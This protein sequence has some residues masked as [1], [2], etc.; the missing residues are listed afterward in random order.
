[1]FFDKSIRVSEENRY[2]GSLTFAIFLTYL[3]VGLPL[4]VIP[5]FVYNGL[6][7]SNTLVGVAVGCQFFATVL[8]RA[9]AG[10]QADSVGAKRTTLKGMLICSMAGLAYLLSALLP[11]PDM[12]RYGI[13]IVGRLFLGLGESLL[14]S[15]NFAWALGLIG[16]T[17]SGKIMSWNGMAIYGS[18]AAGAPL[19]LLLNHHFGFV[20][21]GVSTLV[22]PLLAFLLDWR[23]RPI[24][25]TGGSKVSLLSVAKLV[26]QPG[27]ALALQG[28]G[29]AVIGTFMSLLFASYGWAHA[30]L[31]LS[32]FGVAFVGVR[33]LFGHLPDKIGGIK[34]AMVS[35]L[36]ESVGLIYL[37]G[38]RAVDGTGRGDGGRLR[39][40]THVPRA[41]GGSRQA[42]AHSGAWHGSWG[43]CRV[44]GRGLYGDR[45]G[46]GISGDSSGVSFGFCDRGV[47]RHFRDCRGAAFRPFRVACADRMMATCSGHS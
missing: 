2:L 33:V 8:S 27:L 44:S 19:G 21:L 9:Y 41:R 18:L 24:E 29:F 38:D 31:T 17:K 15:G 36:V 6:N 10:R 7:L 25:T 28:A 3:T 14:I 1:M 11:V 40:F 13:L 47:L 46:N 43:I 12:M 20:A 22:L 4:P 16:T 5:L 23:I 37:G 34:V 42:G 32:C 39:L 35:L 26:W 30:G 45:P